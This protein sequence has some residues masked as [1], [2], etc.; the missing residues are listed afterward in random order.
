[1]NLTEISGVSKASA[2]Q[3]SEYCLSKNKSPKLNCTIQE[4]ARLFIDEGAKEGI[5]G[6]IAFA[7]ACVETGYFK[8]G[9]QVLWYQN[10]YCGLGALDGNATGKNA[11]FKTP[12]IGVRAQIQHLKAYANREPLKQECVDPRFK[13]VTRGI[14]EYVEWLGIQENPLKKGW[15]S[16]SGYGTKILQVLSGILNYPDKQ[17]NTA[18]QTP[19]RSTVKPIIRQILF[20]G[21]ITNVSCINSDGKLFINMN[22]LSERLNISY[23][24]NM[25]MP[26]VVTKDRKL[27]G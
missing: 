7:Q 4:L 21:H 24:D 20:D 19:Q 13:Y 9:G 26:E 25:A 6:D 15:A 14:A 10:N 3:L 17:S 27:L 22:D 12:Q 18:Q 8:Y 16:G 1:M 11:E 2:Y 23:N 5:R